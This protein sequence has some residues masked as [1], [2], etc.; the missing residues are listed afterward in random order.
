VKTKLLA[1]VVTLTF[2]GGAWA[3]RPQPARLLVRR[4]IQAEQSRA[5]SA[6]EVITREDGKSIEQ[7]V[8]RDPRRGIR[9]EAVQPGSYVLIDNGKRVWRLSRKQVTE[10]ESKQAG[11]QQRLRELLGKLNR[12]PLTLQGQ[13]MV[14]GRTADIVSL[15]LPGGGERRFWIDRETGLRL[16]TEEKGADGRVRS[17][18]YYL[19][20]DLKPQLSDADFAPPGSRPGRP[21]V[22]QKQR[23]F[24]TLDDALKAGVSAR[25]PGWLPSGYTLSTVESTPERITLRYSN[26]MNLLSV[27]RLSNPPRRLLR[28]GEG[29]VPLPGIGQGYFVRG[30]DASYLLLGSLPEADLKRIADSLR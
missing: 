14:A 22:K 28:L 7:N 13:D 23:A 18:A 17:S 8:K 4:M 5:F 6:R 11:A 2:V 12:V 16:K 30:T 25:A 20:V 1:L 26:G 27:A 9:R 24:Q 15:G 10:S 21:L 19:S 3:Q 29:F